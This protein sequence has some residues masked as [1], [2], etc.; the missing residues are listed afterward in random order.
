M[1]RTRRFLVPGLLVI[2]G[3]AAPSGAPAQLPPDGKAEFTPVSRL[4]DD[5][6]DWVAAYRDRIAFG[7]GERVFVGR[8]KPMVRVTGALELDRPVAEGVIA[9]NLLYLNEGDRLSVID[10]DDLDAG[11]S[12]AEWLEPLVGELHIARMDDYLVVTETG[13]GVHILA[14]PVPE[15]H[16]D[17]P[18]HDAHTHHEGLSLIG[19]VRLEGKVTAVAASSR[20]IYA[21]LDSR[22]LVVIDARDVG[23]A[24]EV[25][26][27]PFAGGVQ[28]LQANGSRL[29]A[30]GATGLEVFDVSGEER[31]SE[32]GSPEVL[33][34][35]LHLSG[36]RIHVAG[37]DDGLITF[38]ETTSIAATIDVDVGDNFF[39][40]LDIV[41]NEGDTVRWTKAG[42][43][44][45]HNVQSC[46][47]A[48]SGCGGQNATESF[49]SGPVTTSPFVFSHSFTTAG[50]NPYIC[51]THRFSPAMQGSVTV[52]AAAAPPPGVP[53]GSGL[54]TPLT[55]GTGPLGNL[56]VNWDATNCPDAAAYQLLVGGGSQLPT[57][58]SGTY[59][60]HASS[61]CSIGTTGAFAWFGS[62]DPAT[63]PAGFYWFLVVAN[64]GSGVEGSWGANTGAVERTGP[65]AAGSSNTCQPAKDLTNT[66][67]Q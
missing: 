64:D 46:T 14:L 43:I 34:T 57:T 60:L 33:G 59:G 42:T 48:T 13:R 4:G 29:Y 31:F 32:G 62:P 8:S 41:V 61:V 3:L 1:R 7:S 52:N 18:G 27:M 55:V 39:S 56:V 35:S 65:G 20:W 45:T 53:D 12:P 66:C 28:A 67:G 54:T 22:E 24:R 51:F 37:G 11:A 6:V 9:D 25:R 58:F 21:V 44:F 63:D 5:R 40:P 36:R 16:G 17:M 38:H 50:A 26:R 30:L 10:L 23:T 47:A 19:G 49:L 2:A 15:G